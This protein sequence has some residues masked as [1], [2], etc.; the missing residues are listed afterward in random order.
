M[1]NVTRYLT[2]IVFSAAGA[3]AHA[4][5]AVEQS[6]CASNT[7]FQLTPVAEKGTQGFLAQDGSSRTPQGQMLAENGS[8][9]T[10]QGQLLDEQTA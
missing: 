9:R 2:A 1:N 4:N 5:A 7:C 10:P 6:A 8:S 3:A